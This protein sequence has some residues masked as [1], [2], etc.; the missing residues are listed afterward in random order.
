MAGGNLGEI[1]P[2]C[3][4]RGKRSKRRKKEIIGNHGAASN[5]MIIIRLLADECR[6]PKPGRD[7]WKR[8]Q[9][10]EPVDSSSPIAPAPA[11]AVGSPLFRLGLGIIEW[12][13]DFYI[14]PCTRRIDESRSNQINVRDALK[15]GRINPQSKIILYIY[16]QVFIDHHL[17]QLRVD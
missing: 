7:A 16:S 11:P 17:F 3:N 6:R 5:N 2:T 1:R 14:V 12:T 13:Q 9:E 10:K 15:V 8:R 4:S